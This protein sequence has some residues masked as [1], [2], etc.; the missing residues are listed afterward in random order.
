MFNEVVDLVLKTNGATGFDGS[1]QSPPLIY[2]KMLP[3]AM[4]VGWIWI[5][6]LIYAL[7]IFLGSSPGAVERYNSMYHVHIFVTIYELIFSWS[8]IRWSAHQTPKQSR[9]NIFIIYCNVLSIV[10]AV[11]GLFGRP[12]WLNI[13]FL[14]NIDHI[15]DVK[16]IFEIIRIYRSTLFDPKAATRYMNQIRTLKKIKYVPILAV[17]GISFVYRAWPVCI[18]LLTFLMA[19]MFIK[20]L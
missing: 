18:S 5:Q 9:K 8:I 14:K 15:I 7:D 12:L 1:D 2:M 20:F 19:E 4:L 17:C 13:F 6:Y 16:Y 11:S 3:G 10:L